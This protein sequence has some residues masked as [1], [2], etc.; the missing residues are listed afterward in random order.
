M[1]RRQGFAAIVVV[2]HRSALRESGGSPNRDPRVRMTVPGCLRDPHL[3]QFAA[4]AVRSR[5]GHFRS[6]LFAAK[7][8]AGLLILTEG[9]GGLALPSSRRKEP[10]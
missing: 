5:C 3:A 10:P 9:L 8:P 4:T 6:L 2:V 1:R 7:V